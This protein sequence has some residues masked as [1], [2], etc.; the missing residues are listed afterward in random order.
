MLIID[1]I[2]TSTTTPGQSELM[3]NDNEGVDHTPQMSRTEALP[4][5]VLQYHSQDT[6]FGSRSYLFARDTVYSKSCI[7]RVRWRIRQVKIFN[8]NDW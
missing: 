6:S 7:Q 1:V 3:S 8:N 2:L 4:S 5:N